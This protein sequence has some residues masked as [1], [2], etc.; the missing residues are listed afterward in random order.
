MKLKQYLVLSL[1]AATMATSFQACRP[2]GASNAVTGDAAQ[3][4]YI[5][6]GQYDEF[7]NFVSGGFSGQM[8]VY[9]LPSGR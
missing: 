1:A 7:Y 5:P 9:G 8:S 3:R 2:K 4:T 6:P